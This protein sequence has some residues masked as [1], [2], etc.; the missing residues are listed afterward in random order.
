[1]LKKGSQTTFITMLRLALFVFCCYSIA[2]VHCQCGSQ[3]AVVDDCFAAN[4]PKQNCSFN[5]GTTSNSTF[6]NVDNDAK[7]CGAFNT[8]ICFT[9]SCCT[10]CTEETRTFGKCTIDANSQLL[11][12]CTFDTCGLGSGSGSVA[13]MAGT[14]LCIIVSILGLW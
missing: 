1:M 13:Q 9:V 14:I 2:V 3:Q 11:K 7:L 8:A 5:S 6:V 4:C 10:A 12:D